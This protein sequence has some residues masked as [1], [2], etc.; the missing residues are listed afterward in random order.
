MQSDNRETQE[1][2]QHGLTQN[3]GNVKDVNLKMLKNVKNSKRMFYVKKIDPKKV[4]PQVPKMALKYSNE[5]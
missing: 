4:Q 2:S 1:R 3:G 5:R